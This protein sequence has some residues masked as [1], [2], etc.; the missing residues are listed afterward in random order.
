[1]VVLYVRNSRLQVDRLIDE[2]NA[3]IDEGE[4]QEKELGPEANVLAGGRPDRNFSSSVPNTRPAP[5]DEFLSR[6]VA[7]KELGLGSGEAGK[8]GGQDR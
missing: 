4:Q 3:L 1:M 8:I 5:E 6:T 2:A 7:R